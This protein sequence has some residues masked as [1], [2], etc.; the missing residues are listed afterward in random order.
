MDSAIDGGKD[1]DVVVVGAGL[2]G[3]VAARDLVRHG[4]GVV[5]LEARPRVG[6]RVLNG[7]LSDGTMVEVGGQWVGPTQDRL[8]SLAAELGVATFP[9]YNDGENVLVHHGRHRRYQG[10]IPRLPRHVL[11]DLGQAQLR[12][13]R[14]ARHVPLEAPWSATRAR[15][16]DGQTL[17]T[18]I[19]R[20]LRTRRARDMFSLGVASV[21]AAE[22]SEL[23]LLYFLFSSHSGGLLD[24]LFNVAGGAQER[25]FVGGSQLLAERLA[26]RLGEAVRLG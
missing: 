13:D 22:P 23:S 18:W 20:H 16:W 8:E 24:R 1:T 9:T 4:L 12:L 6:G 14:M 25:R 2:A 11:A 26:E 10:A 3:L 7:A 17:E 19:R 21:F 5:V 15:V